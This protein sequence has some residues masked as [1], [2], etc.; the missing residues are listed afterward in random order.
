MHFTAVITV[1]Y[2]IKEGGT[3]FRVDCYSA[4]SL[5]HNEALATYCVVSSTGDIWILV[6]TDAVNWLLCLSR[7]AGRHVLCP[8]PHGLA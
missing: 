1:I 4:G 6:T 7:N 3:L 2:F 5:R 8:T